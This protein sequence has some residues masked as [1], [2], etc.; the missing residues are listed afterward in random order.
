MEGL[1]ITLDGK[2]H[3]LGREG[4]PIDCFRC[5]ICCERYQ[6][7]VT[8]REIKSISLRLGMTPDE[9]VL[10]CTQQAPIQEG[11]LIR[12][13]GRGCMFLT[14]DK[15]GLARCTI[16]DVRPQACQ[17]WQAGL[18]RPECR[19][20]LGRLKTKGT[21]LTPQDMYPSKTALKKLGRASSG[22]K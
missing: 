17:K 18:H 5:G 2:R 4:R 21:L 10:K 22:A 7:P 20:G 14:A 19:E 9:F 1:L 11:Y 6:P 13:T 3:I 16:H 15:N 8:D 12:R